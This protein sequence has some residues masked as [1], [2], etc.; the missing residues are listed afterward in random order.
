MKKKIKDVVY[1]FRD[2]DVHMMASKEM[3]IGWTPPSG[4]WIKLNTN[5][6]SMGDTVLA[7]CGG[8]LRDSSR[9]WLNGFAT[10]VG[11]ANAL[12]AEAWGLYYGLNLAWN[13]GYIKLIVELDSK[14]LIATLHQDISPTNPLFPIIASC[15]NIISR[16]WSI[17]IQHSYREGNRATNLLAKEWSLTSTWN[18]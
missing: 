8:V 11:L 5:G 10:H 17:R 13:H 9:C 3:L 12:E 16:D 18:S 2:N 15:K 6:A 7:G 4:D 14:T 1:A